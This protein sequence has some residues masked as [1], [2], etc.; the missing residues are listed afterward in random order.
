MPVIRADRG[1]CQGYA[2]CVLEAE[3]V[4]DVDDEGT[5]VLLREEIP[6]AE[7]TRVETAVRSCPASA[8]MIEQ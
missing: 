1:L 6:E 8:L 2:N 5:V 4:F 3:D 7:R